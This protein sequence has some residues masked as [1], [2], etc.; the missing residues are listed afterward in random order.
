MIIIVLETG[1]VVQHFARGLQIS[2]AAVA[3]SGPILI[4]FPHAVHLLTSCLNG[5]LWNFKMKHLQS[6]NQKWFFEGII[7]CFMS[8][9]KS[10]C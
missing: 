6:L 2:K 5:L 4:P 9:F 10:P 8:V 3:F 7:F 1:C